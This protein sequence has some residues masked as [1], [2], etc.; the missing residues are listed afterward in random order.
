MTVVYRSRLTFRAIAMS[1]K[2]ETPP[3]MGSS[4]R[5]AALHLAEANAEDDEDVYAQLAQKER[6]L[7]LAAELG[8]ALLDSNQELQSRY[9]Q[10]VEEYTH[11]FEVGNSC[12]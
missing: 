3:A 6:D 7:I 4:E 10:M 1:E 11:K 12:W 9:D 5:E 8:K 2:R